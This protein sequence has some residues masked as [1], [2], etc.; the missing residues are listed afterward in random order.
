MLTNGLKVSTAGLVALFSTILS[1][2]V[3]RWWLSS[4]HAAL[5]IGWLTGVLL[6]AMAAVVVITGSR[7]WRMRRGRTHVEPLVAAR[8]LG[9]K[10]GAR[11]QFEQRGGVAAAVQRARQAFA[12]HRLFLGEC[13]IH[14]RRSLQSPSRDFAM[15]P[16]WISFEPP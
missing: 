13:K 6:I 11:A 4:G 7:M 12:Q 14:G 1:W 9:Q 10:R 2:G 3:G 5:Q 16:R 8:I 15:I